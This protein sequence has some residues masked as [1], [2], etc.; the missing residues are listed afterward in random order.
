MILSRTATENSLI[1]KHLIKAMP[2]ID[3]TNTKYIEEVMGNEL[4]TLNR[5]APTYDFI[6]NII[7]RARNT[8]N[9]GKYIKDA[10]NYYST[11]V[12][13]KTWKAYFAQCGDHTIRYNLERQVFTDIEKGWIF[14]RGVDSRG[15]QFI[16]Q[17]PPFRFMERRVFEDG[18]IA[19]QMFFSKVVFESLVTEDCVKKGGDGYIEL[20]TNFFPLLTGT[21][22]GDLNSYSPIYK[23]NVFGLYKNTHKGGEIAVKREELIKTI[24]PEY[25]DDHGHLKNITPAALHDSLIKSAQGALNAIPNALLVSNFY[26]GEQRGL[27]RIFFRKPRPMPEPDF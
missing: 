10:D 22:K 27:S 2:I 13:E 4:R 26:I 20:P 1:N 23:L 21:D 9:I 15:R 12:T 25:L 7:D 16:S 5:Y 8:R 18:T 14:A 11:W 17:I 24:A 3:S 6:A 19:R